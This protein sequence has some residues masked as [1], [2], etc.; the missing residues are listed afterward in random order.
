MD[1]MECLLTR[2]SIRKYK[3]VPVPWDMV[4]NI[5]E[6]GRFAPSSGN[7]QNWKFIVCMDEG[8]RKELTMASLQQSWMMEAPVHIVVLGEID[9][10]KRMYGV[11]GERL[12]GVQNVAAAVMSMLLAAHAQGLGACWVGAFDED[13]VNGLVS[14]NEWQRAHAIIT[15]G[16]PDEEVPCPAKYKLDNVAFLEKWMG[17]QKDM[18]KILGYTSAGVLKTIDKGKKFIENMHKKI[19]KDNGNNKNT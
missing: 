6:A 19:T 5:L 3:D 17:R 4:G 13:K 12:Y 1:T 2:R 7:I 11:R 10:P 18:N 16:Y 9:K 15:V 8:K 14:A